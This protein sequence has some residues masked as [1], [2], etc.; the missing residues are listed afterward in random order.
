MILNIIDKYSEMSVKKWNDS[1][2]EVNENYRKMWDNLDIE[3]LKDYING[4]IEFL[5]DDINWIYP[6][7]AV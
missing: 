6:K 5:P 2:Q 3:L 4:N 7:K 1:L